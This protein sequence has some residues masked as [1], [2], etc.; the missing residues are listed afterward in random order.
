MSGIYNR[1]TH[2]LWSRHV[3]TCHS[4][5]CRQMELYYNMSFLCLPLDGIVLK[6]IIP[7]FDGQVELYNRYTVLCPPAL[8]KHLVPTGNTHIHQ[9]VQYIYEAQFLFYYSSYVIVAKFSIFEDL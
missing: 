6:H 2:L 9:T 1:S 3:H 7:V 8:V 5:V 4:S